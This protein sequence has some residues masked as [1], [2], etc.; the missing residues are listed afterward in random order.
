[1]IERRIGFNYKNK[2]IQVNVKVCNWWQRIIGLMF[3]RKEN[4]RAL[5]FDFKRP[6]TLF[7]HSWFVFFPFVAIF[8]DARGKIIE[9]RMVQPFEFKVSP[10]KPYVKLIEIPVNFKYHEILQFLVEDAKGL[11]R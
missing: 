6:V 4:A 8:L 2:K 3:A 9:K 10:S 5:L 7:I 11:N 1:M